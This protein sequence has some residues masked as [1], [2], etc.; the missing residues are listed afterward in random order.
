M[1]AIWRRLDVGWMLLLLLEDGIVAQ[2]F[3]LGLLTV[4][5]DWMLF[6][7]LKMNEL[8]SA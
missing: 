1:A 7:A 2:A 6:V 8:A 5:A 3:A 4:F